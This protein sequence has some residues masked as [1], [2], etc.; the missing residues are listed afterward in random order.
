MTDDDDN[1]V[2]LGMPTKLDIPPDR[3]LTAAVGNLETVMVI[4]YDKD[5]GEYFAASSADR[6]LLV[7]ILERA[8]HNLLVMADD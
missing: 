6:A 8:K 7:W 5:G 2:V 3:V 1:V 4:G